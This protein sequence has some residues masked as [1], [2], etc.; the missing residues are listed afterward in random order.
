M[1]LRE[2]LLDEERYLAP[3]FLVAIFGPRVVQYPQ[4]RDPEVA[5]L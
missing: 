1:D 3:G 5:D 4:V 2:M